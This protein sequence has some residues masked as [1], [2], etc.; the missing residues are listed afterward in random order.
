MALRLLEYIVTLSLL[1]FLSWS[2]VSQTT[3]VSGTVKDASTGEALPFVKIYFQG[4]KIATSTDFEGKY[5]LESYY[6][7]DSLIAHLVGYGK[8]TKF[9]EKDKTQTINFELADAV[10]DLG[11]LVVTGNK[12]DKRDDPAWELWKNVQKYKKINDREKLEAYQ[13]ETYNK[14]EFDLNNL[15]EKFTNRKVFKPFDFI[16]DNVDST[17]EK[18]Y[19][20][21]FMTESLSDFYYRKNPKAEREYVKATQISGV[22]NE[23]VSQFMGDMYQNVNIYDS[24]ISVFGKSFISPLSGTARLYYDLFLVDS[25]NINGYWCYKLTFLPKRKQEPT[26]TGEVWITDTTY[27]VKKV[28][29]A[30][31]EDANINFVQEL[32][33]EQEYDQVDKEVWMLT[34]DRL[35]V[36]LYLTDKTMGFYGR[37]T[38][39]YRDFVIN[40]PKA[41]E[42]YQG[43]QNIFVADDVNDKPDSFWQEHRHHQLTEKEQRI[44]D[45]M[46]T[47]ETIPQVQTYVDIVTLFVTGYKEFGKVEIGPITKIISSNPVEGFRLGFG[48]RT[49]NQ[50]STRLEFSGWGAYGFTDKIFKYRGGFRYMVSKQPRQVLA[51]SYKYD[52]EQLG[53]GSGA[54]SEDNMLSSIARRRPIRSFALINESEISYDHEWFPGFNS[55]VI[56]NWSQRTPHPNGNLI[57]ERHDINGNVHNINYL[58]NSEVSFH[59]RFA[60]DEKFV[61]GEF[62]RISLGT[63]Y[64]VLNARYSYGIPNF[65]NGNTEYH[66]ATFS[67]RH[68]F[69][70]GILGWSSYRFE[71]G[72]YWGSVPYPLLEIF[73]GNETYYFMTT[74]FNTMNYFEFVSDTYATGRFTHHFD[75]FFL[76]RIPLFR[77]LKWRE[78]ISV[79][80]AVGSFDSKHE[81]VMELLP[82]MHTLR[83]PFVEASVGIE[84]I[85]KILRVDVIKRLNYLDNPDIIKWGIRARFDVDF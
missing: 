40:Q 81:D 34:E 66:K 52:V 54:I 83:A 29:A 58:T 72:K 26:F 11:P 68:W 79:K 51:G 14:V 6:A 75:G 20:P 46:D 64:P 9:V 24:R 74:A 30:V 45:M 77:R 19:L 80:A 35:F 38:T 31:A 2:T 60:Y 43:G 7:S 50:F 84:N 47:L 25:T 56:F 28:R 61:S 18:P 70:I 82:N 4:T 32:V 23:S 42:F 55:K 53:L 59:T 65:L 3:T 62:D 15:T 48:L 85:F 36:D 73:D 71:M 17:D 16:F 22:K 27:A 67:I 33:V 49:S 8:V 41:D 5:K 76:N 21:L 39:S 37:K 13:Y 63:K 12:K 1:L 57:Y 69:P 78:V 10:S 44:F